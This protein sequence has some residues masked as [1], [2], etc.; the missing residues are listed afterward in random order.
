MSRL[1][2][3]P[4]RDRPIRL[5]HSLGGH[6]GGA[7]GEFTHHLQMFEF[8]EVDDLWLLGWG[9][10]RAA[11]TPAAVAR[12][13]V[14]L[15]AHLSGVVGAL[16]KSVVGRTQFLRRSEQE[17]VSVRE[18]AKLAGI[19]TMLALYLVVLYKIGGR[20]CLQ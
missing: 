17:V 16:V 19:F 1:G 4:C 3:G 11:H 12:V 15:D 10:T 7:V 20:K 14:D 5:D 2:V 6:R 8:L 18:V 13:G 9:P